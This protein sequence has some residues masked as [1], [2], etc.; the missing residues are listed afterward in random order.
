MSDFLE[1]QATSNTKNYGDVLEMK[2]NPKVKY[3]FKVQGLNQRLRDH[4]K[5]V[6]SKLEKVLDKINSKQILLI[7]QQKKK[8]TVSL[9]HKIQVA[10]KSLETQ[11]AKLR[12]YKLEVD[13]LQ[14]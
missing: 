4:L 13:S 1:R 5:M 14:R 12:I 7:E 11:Q 9:D 10:D 8:V 3:L 2:G 6:N